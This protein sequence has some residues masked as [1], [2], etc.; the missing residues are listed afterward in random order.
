MGGRETSYKKPEK[1]KLDEATVPR[2]QPAY[3]SERQN[4]SIHI[5][6]SDTQKHDRSMV[7]QLP[8]DDY[9]AFAER[10]YNISECMK[11]SLQIIQQSAFSPVLDETQK[12]AL[13]AGA[14]EMAETMAR[15]ANHFWDRLE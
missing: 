8:I 10:V 11:V 12:S 6:T 14:I 5:P 4:M 13:I 2:V 7:S 15:E 9:K 3:H 1:E